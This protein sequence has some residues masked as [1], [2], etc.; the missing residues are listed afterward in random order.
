MLDWLFIIFMVLAIM[1]M[2]IAIMMDFGHF[3]DTVIIM[4]DITLWFMLAVSVM[5]IEI[6]YQMFNSTSGQIESGYHIFSG[7]VSPYMTYFFLMMGSIMIIYWVGYIFGPA[8][9]GR[10]TRRRR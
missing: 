1:L 4:V 3:W 7:K 8:I 10:F 2:L 9:F 6:P 5:E